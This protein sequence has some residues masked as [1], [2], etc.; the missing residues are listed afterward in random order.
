MSN[1]S[2]DDTQQ[3][4]ETDK[5]KQIQFAMD[6]FKNIQELIRFID[7]KAAAVLVVYGFIITAYIEFSKTQSFINPFKLSLVPGI[8]SSLIFVFGVLTLGNIVRQIYFIIVKILKPR[9]A[10][11]YKEDEHSVFYF[12]HISSI[13]KNVL[14]SRLKSI[15]EDQIIEEI[16]GQIHE[17]AKIMTIKTHRLGYVF[18]GLLY[19]VGF[20]TVYIILIQI[21]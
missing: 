3:I 12:E 17:V 13:R 11:N 16:A 10:M 19:T 4:Y 2:S 7:Q 1:S 9:L 15:S 8:G 6:S 18:N 20:L 14:N 21:L 5:T